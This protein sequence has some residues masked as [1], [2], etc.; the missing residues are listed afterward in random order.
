VNVIVIQFLNYWFFVV[1]TLLHDLAAYT[2]FGGQCKHSWCVT[3]HLYKLWCNGADVGI[4]SLAIG[5][6]I[7]SECHVSIILDTTFQHMLVNQ[8]IRRSKRLR[9]P[10]THAC[11]KVVGLDWQLGY[12]RRMF[13][14][15]MTLMWNAGC[16]VDDAVE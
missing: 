14:T 13:A 6:Q 5:L 12:A 8:K 7:P 10:G 3:F 16:I 2:D 11:A 4:G 15:C 9:D 1:Q